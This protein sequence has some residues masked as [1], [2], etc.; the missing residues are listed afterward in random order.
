M[1]QHYIPRFYSVC[2]E[3]DMYTLSDEYVKR[4]REENGQEI[5]GLTIE[6]DHFARDVD[7]FYARLLS[8]ID[9]I[10]DEWLTGKDHYRLNYYEKKELALHLATQYL[11]HPLIGEAEVRNYL[12]LEQAGVDMLKYIMAK[13]TGNEEFEKLKVEVTYEKP[14]LH[15]LLTYMNNDELMK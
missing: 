1:N 3:K 15:A 14:A 6:K 2:C 8:D 13:Q 7:P 10:K 4:C 5:N 12:R 9:G 11:R